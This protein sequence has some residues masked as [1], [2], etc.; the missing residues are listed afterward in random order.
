MVE[1]IVFNIASLIV[2]MVSAIYTPLIKV[3]RLKY[4]CYNQLL[5][6]AMVIYP[7]FYYAFEV[8]AWY[9][10]PALTLLYLSPW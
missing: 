6:V 8:K 5:F 3:S 9:N 1:T 2:T 10:N 4:G 7:A